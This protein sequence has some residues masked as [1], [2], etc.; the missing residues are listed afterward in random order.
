MKLSVAFVVAVLIVAAA[1]ARPSST[2]EPDP[3]YDHQTATYN[4]MQEP[5]FLS[6]ADLSV[7]T[8]FSPGHSTDTLTNLVQ[9][10]TQSIVIGT[11]GFSSW[12]GCTDWSGSAMKIGCAVDVQRNN[13]SFPIFQALVNAIN[14][15]VSVQIMTNNY[16]ETDTEGKIDPLTFLS[17]MGADV[18]FY[19]TTTFYH[20][21]FIMVDSNQAAISSINYSQTS[22]RYNR[23]AGVLISG[24]SSDAQQVFGWLQATYDIDWSQAVALQPDQT[25]N[26]TD[27]DIIKDTSK[28]PVYIPSP[29]YFS[30]AYESKVTTIDN[31]LAEFGII[32]SPDYA[33]ANIMPALDK[34]ASSLYLYI[35][36]VTDT[37]LCSYL[38][39]L[40]SKDDIDLYLLVSNTIFD[41]TDSEIAHACYEKLYDA[42]VYVKETKTDMYQFSHQKFWI[43]DDTTVYLST[44]NW[45]PS[46]YPDN[47]SGEYPP[48]SSSTWI[49]ANR[50]LTVVMTDPDVVAAFKTLFYG[51]F[52]I[53]QKWYP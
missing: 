19:S 28:V 11:P 51:D 43:I 37:T 34:V 39:G 4:A 12:S 8:F 7:S 18:R 52:D 42:G 2:K 23:E 49:N 38:E 3:V 48:Y 53:G 46:D 27:W 22:F 17:L 15:G 24:S 29:P 35:Y 6:N 30:G 36:Q 44:G 21:K 20:A 33:F 31:T 10:A 1:G 47:E 14:R 32:A 5:L 13:E 25:Y 50:D 9:S 16:D 26:S 40:A 41:P 45:S